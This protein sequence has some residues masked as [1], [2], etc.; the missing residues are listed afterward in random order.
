MSYTFNYQNFVQKH[1]MH[2]I[3]GLMRIRNESEYLELSI[4]SYIPFFDEI[5]AVYNRC[6][7]N[8]AE[9]LD[10]LSKEF[11]K[12]KIYHYEPNV[13]PP[14]SEKFIQLAHTHEESLVNY[15]NFTL[16]LANFTIATKIDADQVAIPSI[17][18]LVTD[19][20][21]E[22]D[23]NHFLTFK[24]INLF[25]KNGRIYVKADKPWQGLNDHGFFK[26]NH[27]SIWI[28]DPECKYELFNIASQKYIQQVE[29]PLHYHL[30]GIKHD[31][32]FNNWDLLGNPNSRYHKIA[33]NEWSDPP[34][35]D[36]NNFL[37]DN[38]LDFIESYDVLNIK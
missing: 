35:V 21:R 17:Y 20:I 32:G 24:G 27:E 19:S 5:I 33:F 6:T 31:K 38:N 25:R 28:K 4:R 23:L 3:S 13:W 15:Y 34:V 22:Q 7:D 37:C 30:K 29:Y 36:I 26:I 18:K 16:S 2:G 11:T 14:G 10:R 12:L 1:R 9:I 8:T